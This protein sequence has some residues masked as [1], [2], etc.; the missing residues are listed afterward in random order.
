VVF[1]TSG[2][3]AAFPLSKALR[4][5]GYKGVIVHAT[6]A[7]NLA[8]ES[9]TD[10]VILNTASVEASA[11]AIA[12]IVSTLKAPGLTTIGEPELYGYFSA[13]MLVQILKKVGPDVTPERFQPVAS[14]T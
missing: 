10:N 13:D 3:T 11:P 14:I 6:Y 12:Q 9:A 1:V 4:Q 5:A 2:P 8:A 7:P